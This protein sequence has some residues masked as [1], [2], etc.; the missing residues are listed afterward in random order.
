MDRPAK[1]GECYR[2]PSAASPPYHRQGKGWGTTLGVQAV[3]QLVRP[4]D[5]AAEIGLVMDSGLKYVTLVATIDR[6]NDEG[7]PPL[8]SNADGMCLH[9]ACPG[10][11]RGRPLPCAIPRG[12]DPLAAYALSRD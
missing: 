10:G 9:D 3:V 11:Q 4:E 5:A 8:N 12:S 7:I 1:I 2:S 6:F